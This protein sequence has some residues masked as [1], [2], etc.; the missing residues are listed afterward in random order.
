ME[1]QQHDEHI[2]Y[3]IEHLDELQAWEDELLASQDEEFELHNE[4]QLLHDSEETCF[5]AGY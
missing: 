2:W 4:E 1:P 3:Y 5:K